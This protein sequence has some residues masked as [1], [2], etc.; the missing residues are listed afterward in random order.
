VAE[1]LLELNAGFDPNNIKVL[2]KGYYR[3]LELGYPIEK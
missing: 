2:W 1:K 3:W